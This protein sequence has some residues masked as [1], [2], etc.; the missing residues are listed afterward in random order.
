MKKSILLTAIALISMGMLAQEQIE[1]V[2]GAG[3]ADDVYYSLEN[4]TVTTVDRDNW[5]I[6]FFAH[7]Y[8]TGLMANNGTGVELYTYTEGDIDDWANVDTTGMVWTPM[9]NSLE[10][11]EEGAFNAHSLEHPDYGWGIINMNTYIISGDSLFIIKTISGD[12]KKLS[13]I[14]K[15]SLTNSWE[16]KYANLDGTDEQSESLDAS[17]YSDKYFIYYSI[18][19]KEVLDR[20]PVKTNWDLLFTKYYDYTIPYS[21]TGVLINDDHV[22]AQEVR[23]SGMDQA[24]HED[25]VDSLFTSNISEIGSDWKSFDMGSMQYVLV[26]TVVYYLKTLRETD[27]LYYKIYFTGF[28]GSSEGKYTIMQERLTWYTSVE[29]ETKQLLQ[30]YPNPAS[31]RINVV[32]DLNGRA[33]IEIIDMTGRLVY[34][35]HYNA[36]GFTNYSADISSLNPG[37]FFI[38]VSAEGES[39]VLRFIK[40]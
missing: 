33:D 27:S 40:E 24:T 7:Y 31:D 28:T 11:F 5:D 20:E 14:K 9:Y 34:T 30:V 4:G 38:R 23:E 35:S 21:V 13:I 36:G 19:N 12:Y 1:V 32:F 2:T 15:E 25:Y 8:S 39:N 37:V 3:Y 26:D 16:F 22:V 6:G 10:S 17:L 29:N 18:D